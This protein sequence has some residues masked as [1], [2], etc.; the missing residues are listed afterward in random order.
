M[1]RVLATG[2]VIAL[3]VAAFLAPF[4][5]SLPD[6]LNAVAERFQFDKLERDT[7]SVLSEYSVSL[8]FE[9]WQGISVSVAAIGG[10][11][12]TATIALLLGRAAGLTPAPTDDS[13]GK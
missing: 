1:T 8:P 4:A 6:G 3:A 10:T 9:T 13:P 11:L 2:F 7:P 5:S 12:A